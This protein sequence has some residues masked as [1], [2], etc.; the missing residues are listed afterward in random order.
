[1]AID[2]KVSFMN[3]AEKKMSAEITADT[4]SK[5]MRIIA[6]VLEGYEMREVISFI[7]QTDDLLTCY[8][9]ALKVQGRSEKT[10]SRYRYVIGRTM[11][12]IGVPTRRVTVY[13][14]RAYLAKRQENGIMDTSIESERQTLSAYFN[15]LQREN[16]IDKNPVSNLGTVK[17]A[18][19]EKKTLTDIELARLNN[20]CETV[21]DKA[22][23]NFLASTGCRISEMTDLNRDQIRFDS[24]ECVVHGKGNKERVVYLSPVAGM[25]LKEYIASREDDEEALFMGQRKE[26]LQPGGVRIMLKTL[27]KKAG[28]ENVH[29][30]KFRRTLATELS[31]KGM[32]IQEV[33]RILGHDKIDTTMK[34]VML[35]DDDVRA[36]YRKYA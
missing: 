4:M 11:K 27:A 26:R 31:R 24:L 8:L 20:S 16:L 25:Y 22:I 12:E 6:D 32:S 33:A 18:K 30:H 9:D 21:R 36:S 5:V 10:I 29:P 3:M 34:Y 2:A 23:I 15:W 19:R 7:D 1:M 17:V 14:L 35:N 13:H 28:V